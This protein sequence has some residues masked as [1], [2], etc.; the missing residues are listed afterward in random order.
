MLYE[1]FNLGVRIAFRGYKIPVRTPIEIYC[2]RMN[3]TH[4]IYNIKEF[5]RLCKQAYELGHCLFSGGKY[6]ERVKQ[7]LT[8]LYK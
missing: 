3:C 8:N 4:N 2:E 5:E 6:S 7:S 1:A